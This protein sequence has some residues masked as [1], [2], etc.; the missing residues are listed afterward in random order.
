MVP[1]NKEG[2]TMRQS[3]A[4]TIGGI[5]GMIITILLVTTLVMSRALDNTSE[6][7][8]LVIGSTLG[9]GITV[10]GMIIGRTLWNGG[11]YEKD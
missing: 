1:T 6:L 8:R 7:T 4:Q 11:R 9:I 3:T 2:T 10:T 5:L